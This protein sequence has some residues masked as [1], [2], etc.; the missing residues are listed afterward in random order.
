MAAARTV[1]RAPHWRDLAI[2]PRAWL[3]PEL[4]SYISHCR[5]RASA[6]LESMTE[7]QAATPLPAAHR[8]AGRPYAECLTGLIAHTTEHATQ[9]RQ[10][11]TGQPWR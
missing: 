9:I 8:Y 2:L 3:V 1:C 6:V 4:L 11:I 5:S 10:F 7:E